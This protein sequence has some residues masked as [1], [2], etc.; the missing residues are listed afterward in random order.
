MA[1]RGVEEA[2][3]ELA[4]P[5]VVAGDEKAVRRKPRASKKTDGGP[6]RVVRWVYWVIPAA[7][8]LLAFFLAFGFHQMEAFLIRDARFAVRGP[9]DYGADPEGIQ[10]NGQVRA[11]K[12]ELLRV[13]E[14]D[15]NRSLYLFPV[16][17]RRRNLL[18]VD[19]VK[20][21]AVSR[22]WPNR[23]SV[24]IWERTPVAFAQTEHR[25]G[26]SR[27][28]LIDE[29]GVLL[30]IPKGEKFENFVVL[31][32]MSEQEPEASRKVRVQQSMHFMNEASTLAGFVTEVNAAD[33][34]DLRALI[35]L[36]NAVVTVRLGS[37]DLG[38]KLR[39]F[40]KR[41]PEIH[42]ARPEARFFDLRMGDRVIAVEGAS[43]GE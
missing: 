13:F 17:E 26:S 19:W 4:D 41:F 24:R 40:V 23:I 2:E 18:A 9:T 31:R 16:E 21:A 5:A 30:P 3:L 11:S 20:D 10:I 38:R 25:D 34:G 8:L 42:T 15:L 7:A 35:K 43:R 37:D 27:F 28:Y 32:G 39:R 6:R 1:R 14:S 12:V 36:E 29:E 33:P 22:H